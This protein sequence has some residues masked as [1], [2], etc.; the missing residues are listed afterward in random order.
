MRWKGIAVGGCLALVG[1]LGLGSV[2]RAENVGIQARR[3]DVIDKMAFS[4]RA[5]VRF[6]AIDPGIQ[7]GTGA[8][9]GN[10]GAIVDVTIMAPQHPL[11]SGAFSILPGFS[12]RAGW[13]VNNARVAKFVNPD[14]PEGSTQVRVFTIQ[15]NHLLKVAAKGLGDLPLNLSRLAYGPFDVQVRVVVYDDDETTTHCTL[16]DETVCR[17]PFI[18]AGT[19]VKLECRDGRAVPDCVFPPLD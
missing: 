19:G 12:G 4:N 16:F 15:Q 8:T 2:A 14:A 18:A 13:Q 7:M 1:T 9:V 17:R 5:A 11:I 10:I 3:L 6:L